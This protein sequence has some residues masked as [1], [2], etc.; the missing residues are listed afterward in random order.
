MKD[1]IEIDNENLFHY[2]KAGWIIF[3]IICG[4]IPVFIFYLVGGPSIIRRSIDSIEWY[5]ENGYIKIKRG[6]WFKMEKSIPFD[7]ITD[8]RLVEG[9]LMRKYNIKGIQIQTAG[10]N[11]IEGIITG[12]KDIDALK[13]KLLNLRDESVENKK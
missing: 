13:E 10:S 2:S 1:I 3:C 8:F 6:I 12:A 9:P 4:V 11:M 7:K 5:I